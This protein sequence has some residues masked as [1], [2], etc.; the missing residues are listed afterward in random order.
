M[1]CRSAGKR[2]N[3]PIRTAHSHTILSVFIEPW[4]KQVEITGVSEE[5]THCVWAA[6]RVIF[7]NN[8]VKK[9]KRTRYD[10]AFKL[11]VINFAKGMNNSSAAREFDVIRE[12]QKT[13]YESYFRGGSFQLGLQLGLTALTNSVRLVRVVSLLWVV[14]LLRVVR[15]V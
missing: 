3:R 5:H 11:K 10:A 13:A 14:R 8:R 4:S 9:L 1:Q 12:W 7:T 2:S 15:L 6:A